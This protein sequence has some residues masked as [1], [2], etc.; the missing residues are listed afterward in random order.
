VSVYALMEIPVVCPPAENK[1]LLSGIFAQ[2][3]LTF[4]NLNPTNSLVSIL[5]TD[6]QHLLIHFFNSLS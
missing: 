1:R 6:Q 4:P 5:P 3:S 2:I